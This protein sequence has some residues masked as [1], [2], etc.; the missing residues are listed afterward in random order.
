MAIHDIEFVLQ[1]HGLTGTPELFRDLA[2][3][4]NEG[5]EASERAGKKYDDHRNKLE[6]LDHSLGDVKRSFDNLAGSIQGIGALGMESVG[7]AKFA[8]SIK[9]FNK[10]LYDLSR[11]SK[12]TGQNFAQLK[13][14]I[15]EVG[16][17]THLSDQ[18]AARFFKNIQDNTVG[19]RISA[20]ETSEL[21]RT[22]SREFGP[23]IEDVSGALN[24]LMSLQKKDV[25]I[26]QRLRENMKPEELND[27]A[28]SLMTVQKASAKEVETWMRAAAQHRDGSKSITKEE[29]DLR[30]LADAVQDLQKAGQNFL[31]DWG[32]PLAKTFSEVSKGIADVVSG[33]G[34]LAKNP[35]FPI[36]AK[37]VVL[38]G[39]ALT[40][41]KVVTSS[42]GGVSSM[43]MGQKD[44]TGQRQGGLMGLGGSLKGLFSNIEKPIPVVIRNGAELGLGGPA[45]SGTPVAGGGKSGLLG[46]AGKAVGG[47]A[48]AYGGSA[49]G[50]AVGGRGG[51]GISAA[52]KIG[53]YALMGSA[54]GPLGTLAGAALGVVTSLDELKV[55]FG[56]AS[57]AA[58]EAAKKTEEAS[59]AQED[60]IRDEIDEIERITKIGK[61]DRGFGA[62]AATKHIAEGQAEKMGLKGDEAK[63]E[64]GKW[65]DSGGGRLADAMK[66]ALKDETLRLAAIKFVNEHFKDKLSEAVTK[67]MSEGMTAVGGA[68]VVKQFE[69]IQAAVTQINHG[70]DITAQYNNAQVEYMT[71]YLNDAEG[72]ER[73]ARENVALS[74][75]QA[76]NLLRLAKYA[77]EVH[78]KAGGQQDSW[79]DILAKVKAISNLEG[80]EL[81][82][83]ARMVQMSA[84]GNQLRGAAL[85]QQNKTLELETRISDVYESRK[86]TSQNMVTLKE[87]E[88][89][90]SRAT[91]MG[92]G[93]TLDLQLQAV[94]AIDEVVA[95]MKEQ[96]AIAR[97]KLALNPGS[98]AH[99]DKVLMYET[100]ITQQKTKQMNMVKN[101][102]E[103]YLDALQSFTNVE[104][105]FAKIITSKEM[106]MGEMMRQFK[107]PESMRAGGRGGMETYGATWKAGGQL[108][109]NMEGW[110]TEAQKRGSLQHPLQLPIAAMQNATGP[111]SDYHAAA[112]MGEGGLKGGGIPGL[113]IPENSGVK[114]IIDGLKPP[115]KEERISE[116]EEA[117]FR[118]FKRASQEGLITGKKTDVKADVKKDQE[119]KRKEVD[120]KVEEKD[121]VAT[122]AEKKASAGAEESNAERMKRLACEAE[123]KNVEKAKEWQGQAKQITDQM[124]NVDTTGIG[125][126]KGVNMPGKALGGLIPGS[127]SGDTV[128][129]LLTPGEFVMTKSATAQHRDLLEAMNKNRFGPG[130]FVEDAQ[131]ATSEML[132]S[133]LKA[134][135]S[136]VQTAKRAGR[137][138]LD[139]AKEAPGTIKDMAGG[140]YDAG[141]WAGKK[142]SE[143][144]EGGRS[145]LSEAYDVPAAEKAKM[146]LEASREREARLKKG[147]G[148]SLPRE[149]SYKESRSRLQDMV[150]TAKG[151]SQVQ[152]IPEHRAQLL[153]QGTGENLGSAVAPMPETQRSKLIQQQAGIDKKLVNSTE[154]LMELDSKSKKAKEESLKAQQLYSNKQ[155]QINNLATLIQK[156]QESGLATEDQLAALQRRKASAEADRAEIAKKMDKTYKDES[157]ASKK[158]ADY[159]QQVADLGLQR[160]NIEEALNKDSQVRQK[161]E[162]INTEME[163]QMASHISQRRSDAE[164]AELE[165]RKK[166]AE[167]YEKQEALAAKGGAGDE[168]AEYQMKQAGGPSRKER[169]AA[170]SASIAAASAQSSSEMGGMVAQGQGGWDAAK[171][172][173]K[174]A[175]GTTAEGEK[176]YWEGQ[177]AGGSAAGLSQPTGDEK[178]ES[179]S[180]M[181]DAEKATWASSKSG[182][183]TSM[184]K[185]DYLYQQKQKKTADRSKKASETR[186]KKAQDAQNRIAQRA[187]AY[188]D[189]QYV[190]VGDKTGETIAGGKKGAIGEGYHNAEQV[191]ANVPGAIPMT[192]AAQAAADAAINKMGPAGEAGQAQGPAQ[193]TITSDDPETAAAAA[194]AAQTKAPAGIS[195]GGGDPAAAA[196][197]A[198]AAAEQAAKK[199]P[200]EGNADIQKTLEKGNKDSQKANA[201]QTKATEDV[202][203][204]TEGTEQN[205]KQVRD[206]AQ[207]AASGDVHTDPVVSQIC[208]N[209]AM[210]RGGSVLGLAGGGKIPG[211]G[212]S[213]SVPALLTP[214]EFVVN[215]K[216]AGQHRDL[217]EALNSNRYARGGPVAPP[218]DMSRGGGGVNPR[219]AINIRGDTAAKIMRHVTREVGGVLNDM[220][221]PQ[222]TSGRYTDLPQSG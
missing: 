153:A 141:S 156:G 175:I 151:K 65:F 176:A 98:R 140:V 133:S 97:E 60:A 72:S 194:A 14:G 44:W 205:T 68:A 136:P 177:A 3:A 84:N 111:Q 89:E 55:A 168:Y 43:V 147:V 191:L 16:R 119:T 157:E 120:K 123:S 78:K 50:G 96:L 192:P 59:K 181:T 73:L 167:V 95:S 185:K 82:Q 121:K 86:T 57:D 155:D 169:S 132:K 18:D 135:T 27:Y 103:G 75:Q 221:V 159:A 29:R 118:A 63:E 163:K 34:G 195:V 99:L 88:L 20:K 77:D 67:G 83:M 87:A 8:L 171:G 112:A 4:M 170:I 122:E 166:Q 25:F 139:I 61:G 149:E 54:A 35:A 105:S 106:G 71:K 203:K 204:A 6:K 5:G 217:L 162:E 128:P 124:K 42:I 37:W 173:F 209:I 188:G 104:G 113:N 219:F 184:S 144:S 94:A 62:A 172:R 164:K 199:A 11:T 26:L 10:Q 1:A 214:G 161:E 66:K 127:G 125:G 206:E 196:A 213:D 93:P 110:N 134:I 211:Q 28:I 216:A 53:G 117:V 160:K 79:E 150:E 222:G 165:Q 143:A 32:K 218:A 180:K 17:T 138:A 107:S 23:S 15:E 179:G 19:M 220:M 91:F 64:V 40:A 215:Q 212:N 24:D 201:E 102:R 45:R 116:Q 145:L 92:L 198:A 148:F 70:L 108:Q 52:S 7:F 13:K 9:D 101:L 58:E 12:V 193:P 174:G 158:V 21:A 39:G 31:K 131:D 49:I 129:S 51:A 22:L 36:I 182:S 146:G 154:E 142:F 2:K 115:A 74:Q 190:T 47:A 81:N 90:L 152:A 48:V 197:A 30:D 187:K 109:Y 56:F 200:G 130:G 210:A 137:G 33:L 80:D 183:T 202:K 189:S 126:Y 69:G 46:M 85:A 100:Q 186:D 178:G 41:A 76:D 207:K 38:G 114:Q 208:G